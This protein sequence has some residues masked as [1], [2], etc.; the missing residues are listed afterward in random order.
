MK[1]YSKLFFMLILIL[2]LGFMG[3][4]AKTAVPEKMTHI[5]FDDYPNINDVKG[6]IVIASTK[7]GITVTVKDLYLW[8]ELFYSGRKSEI[9]TNKVELENLVNKIMD[10]KIGVYI[11]KKRGYDRDPE[12]LQ[13]IDQLKKNLE[14]RTEV[15]LIK[16]L[17]TIEVEKRINTSRSEVKKYYLKHWQD[18]DKYLVYIIKTEC[19]PS[20]QENEKLAAYKKIQ[21]AYAELKQGKNFLDVA[22]KY[23]EGNPQWVESAGLIGWVKPGMRSKEFDKHLLKMKPKTYSEPFLTPE[24]YNIIY[25]KDVQKFSE[26]YNYVKTVY[27]DKMIAK[28]NPIVKEKLL[29]PYKRQFELKNLDYFLHGDLN[30]INSDSHPDTKVK[31]VKNK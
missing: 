10:Q 12:F 29:R 8:L 2:F 25:V 6:N 9:L 30:K 16:K 17:V 7:E 4:K 23:T 18:I 14:F 26:R 19:F 22:R 1:K 15:N 5:N 11:A 21:K 20:S 28:L 13:K 24:G 3:C 27:Y 31:N